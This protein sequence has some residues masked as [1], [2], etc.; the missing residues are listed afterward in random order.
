MILVLQVCCRVVCD[1]LGVATL[2]FWDPSRS[3]SSECFHRDLCETWRTNF[4]ESDE[5]KTTESSH[6]ESK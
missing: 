3:R 6:I 5:T 1:F 4:R 2:G